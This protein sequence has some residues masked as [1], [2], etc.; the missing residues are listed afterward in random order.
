MKVRLI[1][2]IDNLQVG[3]AIEIFH[4]TGYEGRSVGKANARNEE[5]STPDFAESR[6]AAKGLKLLDRFSIKG[7]NLN[8]LKE[9]FGFGVACLCA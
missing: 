8:F 7:N 3:D 2:P 4:V 1:K 6:L 9:P 5:I